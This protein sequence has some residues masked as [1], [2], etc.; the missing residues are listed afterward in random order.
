M[1]KLRKSSRPEKQLLWIWVQRDMKKL[2]GSVGLDL[3]GG[4][5]SNYQL[6]QVDQYICVDILLKE[7]NHV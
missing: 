7:S 5:M 2:S 6:F 3:A 4:E 1:A